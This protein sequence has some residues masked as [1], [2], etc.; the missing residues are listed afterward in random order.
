M[1]LPLG[2]I[3]DLQGGVVTRAQARAAGL[4]RSEI[5]YLARR[6]AWEPIRRG[7]YAEPGGGASVRIGSA[8]LATGSRGVASHGSAAAL[9]GLDLLRDPDATQTVLTVRPGQRG[10]RDLDGIRVHR[11]GLPPWHVSE[12]N[13]LPVTTVA[14]TLVDL[15]RALSLRDGVVAMDAALH[16]GRVRLEQLEEVLADCRGWPW[17]RRAASAVKL[18]DAA[19]ESALESLSRIFFCAHDIPAPRTQFVVRSGQ[20]FIART[21]FWWEKPRVA[22]EADGL[23]KYAALADLHAEKLRQERIEA[24]GIRV[25]RWT[26]G[27]IWQPAAARAT[28]ARLRAILSRAA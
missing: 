10:H 22:G 18:T 12:V 6:S 7:M 11:A 8:L 16:S 9:L 5:G 17:I 1:D 4:L 3:A 13:G 23:G 21:D 2:S 26:W 14:R 19:A 20:R 25:V 28:A 27:D 15:T 24:L